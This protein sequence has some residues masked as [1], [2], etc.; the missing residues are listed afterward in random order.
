MAVSVAH[1]LC[2]VVLKSPEEL[3]CILVSLYNPGVALFRSVYQHTGTVH[4]DGCDLCQDTHHDLLDLLFILTNF[5]LTPKPVQSLVRAK[6]DEHVYCEGTSTLYQDLQC[7][8]ADAAVSRG[9]GEKQHHS[10]PCRSVEYHTLLSFPTAVMI[11]DAS[12]APQHES[13]AARCLA[14]LDHHIKTIAR[15]PCLRH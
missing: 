12:S 2:Q 1:L 5:P 3:L 11:W 14:A 7:A 6:C 9:V 10:D 4:V 8:L 15:H 13:D